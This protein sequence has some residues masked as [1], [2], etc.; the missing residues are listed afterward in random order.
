[1]NG[2]GNDLR[3]W[4]DP[5]K[6]IAP[7]DVDRLGMVFDEPYM[8]LYELAEH[9]DCGIVPARDLVGHFINGR[10]PMESE[11]P[12]AYKPGGKTSG[13]RIPAS[14]VEAYKA[15]RVAGLPAPG[16]SGRYFTIEQLAGVLGTDADTL[17]ASLNERF[18]P[19]LNL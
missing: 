5:A 9:L 13:I 7:E 2:N 17:I 15:R 12:N 3:A 19:T 10:P 11:F 8:T 1:M 4:V 16:V 6:G 14:D 18:T